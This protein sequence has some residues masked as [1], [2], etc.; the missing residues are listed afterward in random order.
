MELFN[1]EA[2]LQKYFSKEKKC[3]EYNNNKIDL[4]GLRC[5]NLEQLTSFAIILFS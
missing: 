4:S 1:S 5:Y 3:Y 2:E